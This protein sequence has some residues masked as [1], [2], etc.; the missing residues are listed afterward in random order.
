MEKE[1]HSDLERQVA[2]YLERVGYPSGVLVYEPILLP[3]ASGVR[4]RPDFG[5]LDPTQNEYLALFEVKGRSDSAT[6]AAAAEQLGRYVRA[7]GS[8]PI[9]AFLAIPGNA[10]GTLAFYCL[11]SDGTLTEIPSVD[12]PSYEQLRSATSASSKTAVRA[13][14]AETTDR[15][16]YVAWSVAMVAV[17][18]V[19]VDVYLKEVGN[20]TLL[21]AERLALIGLAAAL[22]LIPY[23]AKL[24]AFGLEFERATPAKPREPAV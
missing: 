3:V 16:R 11:G 13:G 6:L 12:F 4:Y 8:R 24:K 5:V 21:T 1:Y 19:G 7:L 2:Q 22:V 10:P 14:L 9:P 23:A 20:V 17:L 15:F 18:L